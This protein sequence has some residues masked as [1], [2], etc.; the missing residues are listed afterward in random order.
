MTG[1]RLEGVCGSGIG[2]PALHAVKCLRLA[3]KLQMHRMECPGV[4]TEARGCACTRSLESAVVMFSRRSTRGCE[5]KQ[6]AAWRMRR[7]S[8][9][10][11]PRPRLQR[12]RHHSQPLRGAAATRGSARS[13]AAAA[14]CPLLCAQ[15]SGVSPSCRRGEGREAG[16]RAPEPP[17]RV[18][19]PS[20]SQRVHPRGREEK[21]DDGG[22]ASLSR[23]MQRGGAILQGRGRRGR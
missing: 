5:G 19:H 22:V 3:Q 2:R 17:L 12:W 7:R 1:Q 14:L 13:S 15:S 20:L 18:P 8:S 21:G 9:G 4:A 16:R 23:R 10:V 6:Q 11:N